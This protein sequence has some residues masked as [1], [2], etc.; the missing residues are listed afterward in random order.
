MLPHGL[1]R[2]T[3][4]PDNPQR[5]QRIQIRDQC[6]VGSVLR[7]GQSRLGLLAP[8]ASATSM[9]PVLFFGVFFAA[10][11]AHLHLNEQV[12]VEGKQSN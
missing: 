3:R 10:F 4:N 8:G 2:K 12:T 5:A 11:W 9:R 7:T 1:C 6:R